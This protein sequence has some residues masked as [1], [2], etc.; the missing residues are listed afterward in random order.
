MFSACWGRGG[1]MANNEAL[2][3]GPFRIAP[4]IRDGQQSGK[5]F[6]DIPPHVS[7]EGRRTRRSFDTKSEAM[8]EARQLLRSLQ[9][10]GALRGFHRPVA[11]ITFSE[12]SQRWLSTQA[13]RVATQK[14]RVISLETHAFRLKALLG[15]L[16]DLDIERISAKDIVDYQKIRLAVGRSPATINSEIRLL[17]QILSWAVDH[18]LL[19][20]IPKVEP[21]P[22]PRKRL[23]VPTI[24]EIVRVVAALPPNL[25]LLIRF[26]AETG[27]RKGEAFS[28]TWADVDELHNAILIRRK[29][30]WTP[31]TAHS[32]RDVFVGATLMKELVAAKHAALKQALDDRASA[33]LVF[34]GRGGG[35]MWNFEK[36]LATAIKKAGVT[37][38]GAEMH[39]TPHMLRKAHATWLK[40]RGVDD[41]ILQPRLGHAPGSR[42]TA[43]NYVHLPSEAMKSTIIDLGVEGTNLD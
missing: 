12:L 24:E 19:R 10:D 29:A 23:S 4:R 37:R 31:K 11:G 7:L 3:I 41:V 28:L 5:W 25:A 16:A 40:Q 26:L 18:D 35:R 20:K 30:G 38:D 17:R 15:P 6:L 21:I 14:K 1:E 22:E 34:L 9:I 42:V 36:A 43:Y 13:D 8:S 27:C 33:S 32:D 2:K 39:I